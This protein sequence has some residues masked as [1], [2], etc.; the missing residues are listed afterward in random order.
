MHLVTLDLQPFQL[1]SQIFNRKQQQTRF[2]FLGTLEI[3]DESVTA[4][5]FSEFTEQE[6]SSIL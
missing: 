2:L 4:P 1:V 3:R 5:T 6:D